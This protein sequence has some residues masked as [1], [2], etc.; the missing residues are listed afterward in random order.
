M[1]DLLIDLLNKKI[2]TFKA[3]KEQSEMPEKINNLK[4]VVLSE[5]S[6][7]KKRNRGWH[8]KAKNKTQRNQILVSQKSI[9][10]NAIKLYD[11]GANT[12]NLFVNKHIYPGEVE[13]DVCYSPEKS[14]QKFEKTIA[15]KIKLKRQRYNR[16]I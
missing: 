8:K 11:K 7:T 13:K 12:I 5:E 10:K 3:E 15:E 2:S 6:I 4:N 1:Y 16:H 9:V 14:K